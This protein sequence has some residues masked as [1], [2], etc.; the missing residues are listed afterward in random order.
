[1]NKQ[2]LVSFIIIAYNQEKYI[3]EAIRGA[4]AQTYE[5]LEIILSDDKSPDKTFEIMQRLT[6]EYDGPHKVVLNRNEPNLG[7]GGHINRVMELS[8]GEFI[9][10]N[11][12]DDISLAERTTEMVDVWLKSGRKAKSICSDALRMDEEGEIYGLYDFSK[13]YVNICDI[14]RSLKN[15]GFVLGATHGWDRQIFDKF[16]PLGPD[17]IYEDRVLPLRSLLLGT[18][19]YIDKPLIKYRDGGVSGADEPYSGYDYLYGKRINKINK[20]VIFYNQKIKDL[21]SFKAEKCLINI[22]ENKLAYFKFVLALSGCKSI[23]KKVKIL[24]EFKFY[25]NKKAV[26]EFIKYLFSNP[27]MKYIDK[28][29]SK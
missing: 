2:P 27:Y 19:E 23:N 1:M 29:I 12:G 17:V 22:A 28:K 25:T 15:D 4:F 18:V 5:P 9:V 20:N 14:E 13:S 6:E 11:A 3:E 24:F 21:T 10:V 16:G 26:I 7:I 8:Q